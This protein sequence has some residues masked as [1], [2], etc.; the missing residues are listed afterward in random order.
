MVPDS[1]GA[2]S[3]EALC[4]VNLITPVQSDNCQSK[5]ALGA[6]SLNKVMP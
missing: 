5:E 1:G 6:V 3:E 4:V 2:H